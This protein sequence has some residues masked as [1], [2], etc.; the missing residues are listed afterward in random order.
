MNEWSHLCFVFRNVSAEKKKLEE[1]FHGRKDQ[2]NVSVNSPPFLQFPS[3]E[4]IA[5][6]TKYVAEFY[7]NGARDIRASFR[8]DVKGNNASLLLFK[9]VT[10]SGKLLILCFSFIEFTLQCRTESLC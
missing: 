4:S 10:F 7:L 1:S 5:E 6:G 8:S 9:D 2:T 3:L